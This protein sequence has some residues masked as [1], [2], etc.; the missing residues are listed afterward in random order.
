MPN[1]F[2]NVL[3][4]QQWVATA[5]AINAHASGASICA[6]LRNSRVRHPFIIQLMSASVLNRYNAVTKS[7]N[8]VQSP[9]LAGTFGAGSGCVFAPSRSVFGAIGAGST[10]SLITTTTTQANVGANMLANRGGSGDYGFKIRII[11]AS[12]G[13]VEERWIEGNTAGTTPTISLTEPLSFVPATGDLYEI[14]SGK[15]FMLNAGA[16]ASGSFKSFELA[17]NA[18]AICGYTG[19]PTTVSTDFSAIVLDE[20][21]VPHDMKPGEGFIAGSGTYNGGELKCLVAT[22]MGAST[23]TG[24]ASGGDAG[25]LINEYRNFQIRIVE[26]V[27]NKTAVGQR[28]IIASHTAGASPVYTLGSAWAVTPSANAKYVIEYPNL[29]LLRSSAT[30][31]VYTYNY[32]GASITNGTNTIADNTWSTTY[33]G[34]APAVMASGCQWFPSFGIRPDTH[35]YSRHSYNFF[36]RGGN[37]ATCDLFDIAGSITGS[38]TSAIVYDGAVTLNTGACSDYAPCDQEGRFGYLNNYVASVTNQIQRF[39]VKNRV[40]APYTPTDWVQSGTA[41][42]GGRLAT[43]CSFVSDTEKYTCVYLM[44]HLSTIAFELITQ[45]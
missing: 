26:D 6:D 8:F 32:S 19:L 35:K 33:F 38:W 45:V 41:A 36:F 28:R 3:D 29:L 5:P 24:Q 42:V 40:L 7:S 31:T 39:D 14:L 18:L 13:K 30:T 9:A 17:F 20:Q 25:V 2:I 21:Y 16:L 22:A 12:S 15:V 10:E 27:T 44:A 4:R 37:T 34:V 43:L 1:N 23:I 11:S